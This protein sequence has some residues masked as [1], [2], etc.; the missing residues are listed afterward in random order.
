M[1]GKAVKVKNNTFTV[2]FAADSKVKVTFAK[3]DTQTTVTGQVTVNTN[4]SNG[5]NT[6]AASSNTAQ[7]SVSPKTGDQGVVIPLMLFAAAGVILVFAAGMRR[8]RR[9]K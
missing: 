9:S 1:D 7:T 2:T 3:E 8:A 4:G 6:A 5:S